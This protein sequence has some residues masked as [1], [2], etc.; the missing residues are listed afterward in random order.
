MISDEII[1]CTK[2]SVDS[3]FNRIALPRSQPPSV[4]GIPLK[5]HLNSRL[6]HCRACVCVFFPSSSLSQTVIKG[7][8]R[9]SI[10]T[11]AVEARATDKSGE[12]SIS[13]TSQW[14][15]GSSKGS[16]RNG[17]SILKNFGKN[18]RN[19]TGNVDKKFEEN[20]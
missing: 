7:N 17:R 8:S 18:W 1:V 11:F 19:V 3:L 16:S 2:T 10:D 9:V 15:K 12:F 14:I 5:I 13:R 20:F 6:C 4:P